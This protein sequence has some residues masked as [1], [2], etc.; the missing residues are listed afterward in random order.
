MCQQISLLEL[1][2]TSK[3]A[4]EPQLPDRRA[5]H[6]PPPLTP[7]PPSR[8]SP[9]SPLL[10]LTVLTFEATQHGIFSN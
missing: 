10:F 8:V 1:P 3:A 7:L 5:L 2:V 6:P 9:V 4:S